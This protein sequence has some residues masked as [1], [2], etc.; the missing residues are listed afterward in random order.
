MFHRNRPLNIVGSVASL[1]TGVD[2]YK[3]TVNIE[4]ADGKDISEKEAEIALTAA[5][6]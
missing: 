4:R 3:I 5:K 1:E 2:G 6:G